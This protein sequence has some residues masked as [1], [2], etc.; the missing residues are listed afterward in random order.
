MTMK[1]KE[2]E[3]MSMFLRASK[4][5]QFQ[6]IEKQYEDEYKKAMHISSTKTDESKQEPVELRGESK[7]LFFPKEQL[8][9]S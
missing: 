6:K 3:M 7:F 5:M 9:K 2:I 1:D 8:Y 4:Q